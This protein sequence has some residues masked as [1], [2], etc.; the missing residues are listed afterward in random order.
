MGTAT[1]QPSSPA[2]GAH[3][4]P[5]PPAHDW[6]REINAKATTIWVV[7]W[8]VAFF[9]CLY[10]LLPLFDRVVTHELNKKINTLA[11]VER[12][13]LET[14]ERSFL[15]GEEGRASKKSIA[16]VMKEMTRK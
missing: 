10:F 1:H 7:A 6:E 3:N 11:P 5:V 4:Q 8:G 15:K 2:H 12:Q 14:A 13:E 9:L 16:E